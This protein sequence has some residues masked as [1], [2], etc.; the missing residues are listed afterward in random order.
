[1]T[2]N[3]AYMM[4]NSATEMDRLR[5]QARVWQP[6]AEAM[7]DRIGIQAGWACLDVGCGAMGI[8]EPLSRRVGPTG[9]VLGIDLDDV[10]LNGARALAE[11]RQLTNVKVESRDAY[12][13]GL[14]RASFDLAHVRF[15]FAPVGR[16]AELL[17]ETLSLVRPGGVL[18][19]EEPD[20][21]S[22]N[23]FPAAAG[24]D[25]LRDIVLRVFLARGGDFNAGQRIYGML[26]G[27]GLAD[28]QVRAGVLALEP[29]HAYR[30][31][32]ILFATAMRKAIVDCGVSDAELDLAI[33]NCEEAVSD[34]GRILVTFTI[35]QVWGRKPL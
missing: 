33:A 28:L 30:R 17:R 32:P 7:L 23:C 11:E 1:M 31:L 25:R 13:S 24:F 20:A 19:I 22:W 26:R 29:G 8:L 16:D 27:A 2:S 6:E 3:S 35:M 9:R 14:P 21:S 12:N 5:L 10:Q 15:V 18:A 34:P 4:S